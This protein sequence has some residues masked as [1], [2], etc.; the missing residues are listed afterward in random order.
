MQSDIAAL[1][2]VSDDDLPEE[3]VSLPDADADDVALMLRALDVSHAATDSDLNDAYLDI[4]LNDDIGAAIDS[5]LVEDTLQDDDADRDF[6]DPSLESTF[7]TVLVTNLPKSKPIRR[8]KTLLQDH[9]CPPPE[10]VR[11]Y[12]FLLASFILVESKHF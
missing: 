2:D 10:K 12:S 7:R 1:D 6:N 8:L 11:F 5:V 3:E 4:L 9:N